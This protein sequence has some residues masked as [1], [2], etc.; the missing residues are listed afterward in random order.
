M[1]ASVIGLYAVSVQ[2][3]GTP[4]YLLSDLMTSSS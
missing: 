2:A 1:L 3:T 4:T